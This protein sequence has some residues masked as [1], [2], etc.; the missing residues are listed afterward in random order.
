[1]NGRPRQEIAR[2]NTPGALLAAYVAYSS[3]FFD[4]DSQLTLAANHILHDEVGNAD[5]RRH[6]KTPALPIRHERTAAQKRVP[7]AVNRDCMKAALQTHVKIRAQP[8]LEESFAN[9][10]RAL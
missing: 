6:A 9:R 5:R 4:H 3:D 10:E 1:M 7:L 2:Q 8:L